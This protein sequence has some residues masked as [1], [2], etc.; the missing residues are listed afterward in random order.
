MSARLAASR[1]DP[2]NVEHLEDLAKRHRDTV[3][4]RARRRVDSRFHV[5][6]SIASQSSR[7][8]SAA[9]QLEAELMTL[10][11]GNPAQASIDDT[12][13]EQHLAI[14]DAIRER[15]ADGAA[16]AAEHHSRTEM[17]CLI[18]QHLSLTMRPDEGA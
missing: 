7:L 13:V 12:L 3:D 15:D 10:W 2:Q 5:A 14:V 1:A 11:W 4:D 16:R 6:V 9:L 18:E 17:E 8:T